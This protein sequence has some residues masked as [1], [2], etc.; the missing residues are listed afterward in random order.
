MLFRS[1]PRDA[2]RR[3]D[4]LSVRVPDARRRTDEL[5][6]RGVVPDF[7]TPDSIRFGMSPLTTSFEEVRRAFAA[8]R[9]LLAAG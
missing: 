6:A 7:R 4:H 8:L 2:A 1:S 5:V 9:D 3:G